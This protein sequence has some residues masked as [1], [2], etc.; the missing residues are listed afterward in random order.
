MY[1]LMVI[2]NFYYLQLCT[3]SDSVLIEVDEYNFF[4]FLSNLYCERDTCI[5][6]EMYRI[7]VDVENERMYLS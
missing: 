2:N 3:I 4:S 7:N 5:E 1:I 6:L